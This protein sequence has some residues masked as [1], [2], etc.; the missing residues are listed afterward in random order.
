VRGSVHLDQSAETVSYFIQP[1]PKAG[2]KLRH[3]QVQL[4]ATRLISLLL[5]LLTA[6]T[7][8]SQTAPPIETLFLRN[9]EGV[10]GGLGSDGLRSMQ[11]TSDSGFVLGGWS[12]SGPGGNKN[13]ENHGDFDFWIVK[14]DA[15]GACQ[16]EANFGGRNFDELQVVRQTSDNGFILAGSSFSNAGGNK[17]T[18]NY[19]QRD[20]WI[21]KTDSLLTKQWEVNFGG[22]NDDIAKAILETSDGGF[23]IGGWSGSLTNGFGWDDFWVLKLDR[24]G[25]K[26]WDRAYGGVGADRLYAMIPADDGGFVLGGTSSSIVSGNKSTGALGYIDFWLVR[27]AGDGSKIWDKSFGGQGENTLTALLQTSDGGF[28]AGGY[29]NALGQTG[30]KTSPGFGN[31]DF[32]VLK[33]DREGNKTW[34]RSFGGNIQDQLNALAEDS[35]GGFLLGGFSRSGNSGNKTVTSYGSSDYWIVKL[36]RN[37]TALWQHALGGDNDDVLYALEAGA[38]GVIVAGGMSLSGPSGNKETTGYQSP[39][40]WVVQFTPRTA[41]LGTPVIFIDGKPALRGPVHAVGQ[42]QVQVETSFPNGKIFYTL[43]GS[44]P[45]TNSLAYSAPF[46][47]GA[48]STLRVAAFSSNIG[49]SAEADPLSLLITPAFAVNSTVVG[50]GMVTVNPKQPGYAANSSVQ[51][52]A[53]P[54]LGWAFSRWSG[55]LQG[56]NHNATLFVNA[57]KTVSAHFVRL[58]NLVVSVTI[59]GGVSREPNL[60]AYPDGTTVLLKATP[61]APFRFVGWSGDVSAITNPLPLVMNS[62]KQTAAQFVLTQ[63]SEILE[64]FGRVL[65]SPAK[66][67]YEIGETVS[68]TAV[69]DADSAFVRWGDGVTTNP[70]SV[71]IGTNNVIKAIFS[72]G[73][74]QPKIAVLLNGQRVAATATNFNSA[75]IAL[76]NLF[77]SGGP[78]FYTLDE[79]PPNLTS[80]RYSAPFLLKQT[81]TLRALAFSSDFVEA[82]EIGPIRVMIV[83]G[84]NLALA[85]TGQGAVSPIPLQTLYS[86]NTVVQLRATPGTGWGFANWS[87]D[88]SGSNNPLSVPVKRDL[89]ITANFSPLL[90]LRILSTAGG[91]ITR[92]PDQS[93]Y[94]AGSRVTLRALPDPNFAFIGWSGQ[95]GLSGTNNPLELVVQNNITISAHFAE[96]IRPTPIQLGTVPLPEFWVPDGPVRA[97]VVTNGLVYL[98]GAFTTLSPNTGG[99][100]ALNKVTGQTE[101]GWPMVNGPV[102]AAVSDGEGGWYLGGKFNSVGNSPITNL[103]RLRAD[104]TVDLRFAPNPSA[105]INTLVRTNNVLFAGG[106]FTKIGGQI[107]NFLAA[108][109]P[110]TGQASAWDP[111]ADGPVLALAVSGSK[112]YAGGSFHFIG[113][114]AR[115]NIAALDLMTGLGTDWNPSADAEVEAIEAAPSGIIYAAG[116]FRNIGDQSRRF[117]AALDTTSGAAT[118]WNPA[119]DRPVRSLALAGETLY[120]G[121]EFQAIGGE[122]R[123]GLAAL[124]TETGGATLWNPLPTGAT[125]ISKIAA[126]GATIYVAGGLTSIGGQPRSGVAAI[127]AITA[128]PTAWQPAIRGAVRT[129]GV[130]A[131]LIFAGGELLTANGVQR[132][133]LAALNAQTGIPTGWSPQ[134]NGEVFSLAVANNLVY[135]GGFISSVNGIARNSLAAVTVDTGKTAEWNPNPTGSLLFIGPLAATD[136]VVYAGGRFER[137]GGRA[138]KN[139]AGLNPTT[140]GAIGPDWNVDGEVRALTIAGP[141]VY[142]GGDFSSVQNQSRPRLAALDI[143]NRTVTAWNPVA[144]DSVWGVEAAGEVVYAAG[145]FDAIGGKERF[146]IAALDRLT[147]QATDWKSMPNGWILNLGA[148]GSTLF[149]GGIFN[150]MAG[151]P[152][153]GVA[154]LNSLTGQLLDWD[155]RLQNSGPAP[156]LFAFGSNRV[157]IAGQF[158]GVSDKPRPNFAAFELSHALQRARLEAFGIVEQ[159]KFHFNVT[160][161]SGQSYIIQASSNL[162]DWNA[163]ATNRAPFS[164]TDPDQAGTRRF[165]RVIAGQY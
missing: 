3:S 78:I 115:S 136:S 114:R 95:A 137:I 154:A 116:I 54:A 59:G 107:R 152:R 145:K 36:D 101:S 74:S 130:S 11:R 19:G 80:T 66:P 62:A 68:L 46:A 76:Q 131:N 98:G 30:N 105:A 38:D 58:W 144:F 155:I 73:S 44:A 141:F 65:R 70:R 7:A 8:F 125:A 140:G 37:G 100:V 112:V 27:I 55:D 118:A 69:P 108:L 111:D 87:G 158:A 97:M 45:T 57:N 149:A 79:S 102:N 135:F 153:N 89:A 148:S 117:L 99:A 126:D 60:A 142:L 110:A 20:F 77:A 67:S 48:N 85:T 90:E 23:L 159:G 5:W 39:D 56:T 113:A 43:N 86:S 53:V 150:S 122:E 121:G 21:V 15:Q 160:G 32:W 165:Y 83:P 156:P 22:N 31:D 94:L 133:G 96:R 42:I 35:D 26:L 13:T 4:C 147:G 29:S 128:R 63:I 139:F 25:S 41:P 163:L 81:A 72:A 161:S 50:E 84:F 33:L 146:F 164:F 75:E 10:F 134:V 24:N 127:D 138:Q 6:A 103:V 132:P 40:F 64:G 34:E 157:Y 52:T 109:D 82:S 47:V 28:L 71:V 9:W 14:A 104:K 119:P 2:D 92:D 1:S 51:L 17:T 61:E 49:R 18:P 143:T 91:R 129:L 162:V 106:S 88:A 124:S 120:A 12:S 16:G 151:Q 93:G 123:R